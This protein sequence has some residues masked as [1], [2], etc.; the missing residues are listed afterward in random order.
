MGGRPLN[1]ALDA[2]YVA[3]QENLY[4]PPSS[5]DPNES[6]TL[7]ARIATLK[8]AAF[9]IACYLTAAYLATFGGFGM[10]MFAGVD[11]GPKISAKAL[12]AI[13]FCLWLFCQC[14][15]LLA[16]VALSS[17][18]SGLRL[19][20]VAAMLPIFAFLTLSLWPCINPASFSCKASYFQAGVVIGF[21]VYGWALARFGFAFAREGV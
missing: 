7:R 3:M 12:F 4:A 14:G 10:A 1:S 11:D 13:G 15:L 19:L 21:L 9:W 18:R 2:K 8:P 16:P 20:S 6:T 17:K 5:S